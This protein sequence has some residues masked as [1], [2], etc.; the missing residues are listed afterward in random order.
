MLLGPRS[1]PSMGTADASVNERPKHCILGIARAASSGCPSVASSGLP[2]AGQ[3]AGRD[4]VAW[5]ATCTVMDAQQ[6][7][8][9]LGRSAASS[10]V[11]CR[12][13]RV[14]HGFIVGGSDGFA[15]DLL[16]RS[17][18]PL[19]CNAGGGVFST[20]VPT[21]PHCLLCVH[22]A[23]RGSAGRQG[24]YVALLQAPRG[25]WGG[26]VLPVIPVSC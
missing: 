14:T 22:W 2:T 17:D 23:A 19:R 9:L 24:T 1:N 25:W 10:F 5:T 6:L 8:R 3:A 15:T 18:E 12:V 16:P 13:A 4:G 11:V 26:W 7:R 20:V 21:R